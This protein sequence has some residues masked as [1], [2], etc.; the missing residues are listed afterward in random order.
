MLTSVLIIFIL[1]N[2]E[3]ILTDGKFD[4]IQRA[5]GGEVPYKIRTMGIY[6]VVDTT[7]GL[8]LMWDQKT[9]L[10]I[11]LSPEFKVKCEC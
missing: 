6:T 5:P 10:F 8:V 7:A 2:Y 4:V 3:L 11:K 1:Q 9:S